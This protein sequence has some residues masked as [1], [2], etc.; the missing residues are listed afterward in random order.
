M[1][2]LVGEMILSAG[3]SAWDEAFKD[4][5]RRRAAD[6]V[7]KQRALE[8]IAEMQA[9]GRPWFW[10]EPDFTLLLPF[11]TEIVDDPV[12][13]AT[14]R[15]PHH[16]AL[17]YEK[18][19]MP[20]ILR[21]RVR[22]VGYFLLRWQHHMISIIEVLKSARSKMLVSY[23]ALVASPVEQCARICRFLD[24]ETGVDR[25]EDE[26]AEMVE[27]M[28]QAVN[29]NL[30][31][32]APEQPLASVPEASPEQ[33]AL[34]TYLSERLDGDLDDFDPSCY[35]FP[36]CWREYL[37]NITVIRWLLENLE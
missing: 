35:P 18:F 32:N 2:E 3:V 9:G 26:N 29:P 30:W 28:A 25:S 23:E 31:R 5:V 10:K 36:A 1:Q 22:L 6:P 37:S 20:P 21:D 16:S 12:Y 24:A 19:S 11:W 33:K 13:L 15:N 34:F 27:R 8:L 7:Y 14:L 17:S 4:H